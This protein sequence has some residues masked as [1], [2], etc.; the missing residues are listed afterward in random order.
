MTMFC[1]SLRG[2]DALNGL[3]LVSGVESISIY[4]IAKSLKQKNIF[5]F[6][7]TF[8]LTFKVIQGQRS[9][10]E[11]KALLWFPIQG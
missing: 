8:V 6:F 10:C 9:W 5:N 2:P 11:I 4:Y 1:S 7:V 3:K